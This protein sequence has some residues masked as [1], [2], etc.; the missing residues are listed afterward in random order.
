M[1]CPALLEATSSRS[2]VGRVVSPAASSLSLQI[3]V[4]SMCLH[5]ISPS[6]CVCALISSSYEDTGTIG[7]GPAF[8]TSFYLNNLFKGPVS[9]CSHILR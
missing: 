7:L 5:L 6:L 4:F 1:H 3:V 2:S 8:L 9:K